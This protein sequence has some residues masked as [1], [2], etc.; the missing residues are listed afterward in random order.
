MLDKQ[1]IKAN[2]Q[3]SGLTDEQIS[4]IVELSKNDENTV[5]ARKTSEFWAGVDQDIESAFG[6]KKPGTQKSYEFLKEVLSTAKTAK[7]QYDQVKGQIQEKEGRIAELQKQIENGSGDQALKAE[8]ESLKTKLQDEKNRSSKLEEQFTTIK[9]TYEKEIGDL[10][11]QNMSSVLGGYMDQALQGVQFKPGIPEKALPTLISAAKQK[12]LAMGKAELMEVEG[13]Q[14]AVFRD[15]KELLITNP[16]N[17]Q[18][19]WTIQELLLNE[20]SGVIETAGAGGGGTNRGAGGNPTYL[21][22]GAAKTR[23]EAT[24]M[25]QD[26]LLKNEGH[27]RGTLAFQEAEDKILAENKAQ[28]DKLPMQ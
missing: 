2:Q 8:L 10:K 25:I 15:E 1:T 21:N 11:D 16:E 24:Q 18:K 13:R 27:A 26:H 23:V 4:A 14:T 17:L 20:L 19:P 3:L 5:I 28:L 7:E 9:A 6:V 22:L 12:V